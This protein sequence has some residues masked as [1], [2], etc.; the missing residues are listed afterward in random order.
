MMRKG[1]KG[2]LARGPKK[3][4]K[5]SGPTKYGPKQMGSRTDKAKK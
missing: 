2:P 5:Q 4:A 1:K 3:G